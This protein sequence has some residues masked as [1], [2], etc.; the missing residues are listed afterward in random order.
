M[1]WQDCQQLAGLEPFCSSWH[2]HR[3]TE[4]RP[5]ARD[6]R[7]AARSDFLLLH[8]SHSEAAAQCLLAAST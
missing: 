5:L 1:L 2:A 3:C 7:L 4:C 8:G 6:L